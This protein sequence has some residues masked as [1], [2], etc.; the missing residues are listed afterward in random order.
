MKSLTD[1]CQF[2]DYLPVNWISSKNIFCTSLAPSRIKILLAYFRINLFSFN[3][4]MSYL[5]TDI[6]LKSNIPQFGA[7]CMLTKLYLIKLY[8]LC[9]SSSFLKLC[10]WIHNLRVKANTWFVCSIIYHPTYSIKWHN[11]EKWNFNHR[12][13]TLLTITKYIEAF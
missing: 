8:L 6:Y 2:V 3:F 7:R 4:R 1:S 10:L 13:K 12:I 5:Y 9:I 11:C